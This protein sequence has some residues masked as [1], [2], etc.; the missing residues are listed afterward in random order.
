MQWSPRAMER[1]CVHTRALSGGEVVGRT[2]REEGRVLCPQLLSGSWWQGWKWNSTLSGRRE[3][4]GQALPSP[5][6]STRQVHVKPTNQGEQSVWRP[7]EPAP[8][9]SPWID[10]SQKHLTVDTG[11][12]VFP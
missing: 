6:S 8:K 2:G 12:E 10:C 9:Q 3:G 4:L 5:P 11:T 7:Q 1:G